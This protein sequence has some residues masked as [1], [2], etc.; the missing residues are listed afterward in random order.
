MPDW[1]RPCGFQSWTQQSK[2]VSFENKKLRKVDQ[3]K[4]ACLQTQTCLVCDSRPNRNEQPTLPRKLP[5]VAGQFTTDHA[6]QTLKVQ[7][8]H[9]FAGKNLFSETENAATPDLLGQIHCLSFFGLSGLLEGKLLFELPAISTQ[10]PTS[11]G[12]MKASALVVSDLAHDQLFKMR[13]TSLSIS[14]NARMQM[15]PRWLTST[16]CKTVKSADFS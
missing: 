14:E 3:L 11:R 13:S 8:S 10:S 7:T 1:G 2:Q 6:G 12:F 9:G 15:R 4:S 5:I 16:H